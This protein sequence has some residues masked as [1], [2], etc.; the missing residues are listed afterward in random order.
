[1]TRNMSTKAQKEISMM[2]GRFKPGKRIRFASQVNYIG[3]VGNP[4]VQ[5]YWTIW[6]ARKNVNGWSDPHPVHWNW[7]IDDLKAYRGTLWSASEY[8][9][10]TDEIHPVHLV[11]CPGC[12]RE[13]FITV[14]GNEVCGECESYGYPENT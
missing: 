8:F 2:T 9:D 10:N 11:T 7:S 14:G 1:M 5:G 6:E 4:S 13:H 12:K 3:S